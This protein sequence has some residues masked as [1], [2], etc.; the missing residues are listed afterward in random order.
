M[1][2]KTKKDEQKWKKAK[3]L[4]AQQGH[5]ENYGYIMS[6]YKKMNPDY[7]F[8]NEEIENFDILYKLI[9]EMI[10]DR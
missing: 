5:K 9:R 10:F 8:K 4:A 3:E 6:I 7:E 1:P 2:T